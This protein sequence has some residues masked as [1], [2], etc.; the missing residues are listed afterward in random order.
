MIIVRFMHGSGPLR[1]SKRESFRTVADALSACRE[2]YGSAGFANLKF[3]E[4]NDTDGGRIT[5]TTPGGRGGRNVAFVDFCDD[6]LEPQ[7]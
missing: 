2:I 1:E 3:I 4:E 7:R 6:G 5:A